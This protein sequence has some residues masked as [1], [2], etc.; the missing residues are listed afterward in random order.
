M[1]CNHISSDEKYEKMAV[2]EFPHFAKTSSALKRLIHRCTLGAPEWR[3]EEELKIV[4]I[5]PMFYP[6]SASIETYLDDMSPQSAMEAS[7]KLWKNCLREMELFIE[8]KLRFCR[9]QHTRDDEVLLGFLLRPTLAEV[10]AI[11]QS[12][13]KN[14]LEID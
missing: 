8:V 12:A 11:L 2:V 4:R 5:G 13:L 9:G 1:L 3:K 6:K 14:D 10:H 7:Q